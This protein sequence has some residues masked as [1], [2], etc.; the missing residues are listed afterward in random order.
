MISPNPD[1]I[2]LIP[3]SAGTTFPLAA[4][5]GVMGAHPRECGDHSL[6]PD[7]AAKSCGS[8]PRVRGPLAGSLSIA[9]SSRLIPAGAGT[10]ST[11]LISGL[12]RPAH[13]RRCGDHLP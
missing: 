1:L 13:P 10:T 7:P 12:V 2:R 11:V 3:A 5:V 4:I 6:L 9:V 8:S